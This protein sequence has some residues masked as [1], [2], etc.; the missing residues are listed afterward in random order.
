MQTPDFWSIPFVGGPP[1]ATDAPA[2]LGSVLSRVVGGDV[3]PEP[4]RYDDA[5]GIWWS[6]RGM[7]GALPLDAQWRASCA[8]GLMRDRDAPS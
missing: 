3:P 7:R 6:E 1:V 4:L 8:L 5:L 2:L